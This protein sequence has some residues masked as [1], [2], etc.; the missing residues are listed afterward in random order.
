MA[1]DRKARRSLERE[2]LAAWRKPLWRLERVR[3]LLERLD[4]WWAEHAGDRLVVEQTDTP[5][6]GLTLSISDVWHCMRGLEASFELVEE[7]GREARA[8]EAALVATPAKKFEAYARARGFKLDAAARRVVKRIPEDVVN[9]Y[10]VALL[11]K[12]ASGIAEDS[13]HR[14]ADPE[15]PPRLW[16]LPPWPRTPPQAVEITAQVHGFPTAEACRKYLQRH[17]TDPDL[18]IPQGE[19]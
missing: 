4:S 13:R 15:R 1:N 10:R 9:V 18:P 3:P 2:K 8:F 5:V 17:C 6:A 19:R 12:Q 11:D 16:R 14:L 7:M